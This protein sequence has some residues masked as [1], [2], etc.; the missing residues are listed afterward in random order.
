MLFPNIKFYYLPG[1]HC[2]HEN[3]NAVLQQYCFPVDHVSLDTL[4]LFVLT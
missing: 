1:K 4:G 2:P 3:A